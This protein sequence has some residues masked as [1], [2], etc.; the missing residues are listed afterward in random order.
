M[1]NIQYYLAIAAVLIVGFLL[2]RKITS[3]VWN[4]IV[5]IIVLAVLAWALFELGVI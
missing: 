1:D 3:C 4:I 5:G 2:V